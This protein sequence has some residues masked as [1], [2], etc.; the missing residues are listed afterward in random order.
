MGTVRELD[1]LAKKY[2]QTYA[3][4]RH[5]VKKLQA[6]LCR[7][8]GKNISFEEAAQIAYELIGLYKALAGN[9]TV[10]RGGL[11]NRNRYQNG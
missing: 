9:K 6:I 1:D 2:T 5:D 10:V 4:K 3:A 11:K 7:E 8:Q